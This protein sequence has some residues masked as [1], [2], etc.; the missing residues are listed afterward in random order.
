MLTTP[1]AASVLTSPELRLTARLTGVATALPPGRVSVEEI[2]TALRTVRGGRLP[3]G[4]GPGRSQ[5]RHLAAPLPWIMQPHSVSDRTDA[6]VEQAGRLASAASAEAIKTA[7][8]DPATIGLVIFVSCTGFVLPSLD[9]QLIPHLGLRPQTTRLPIA[10]L[11]CGGGVAALGR[12]HDYLR[13]YPDRAVLVV[14]VE[15]PSLTY[16]PQDRSMDNL[17]AALVFGDGAGAA[18]MDGSPGNGWHVTRTGSV[19]VPEGARQLGYE[20]RDGGLRIILNRGLPD[21]IAAH[22][23]TAVTR[24]LSEDGLGMRDLDHLV[25]HPGGPRVLDAV[26]SSLGLSS[27]LLALS[28]RAYAAVGN[29]SSATIFFV[30]SALPRPSRRATALAIAFGPGLS[31]ELALLRYQP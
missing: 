16:Q 25:A 10:E 2:W 23:P 17:V 14:A 12:A 13:A 5:H 26:A 4:T 1:T 6:Y 24:F 18:V 22:L 11:G 31:I 7:G 29:V 28:E 21:V 20:L 15:V 3:G 27:D 19:L 9:A 30:L 8:V